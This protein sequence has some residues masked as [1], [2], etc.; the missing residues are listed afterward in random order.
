MIS[1]YLV[2]FNINTGS[3][4]KQRKFSG[5]DLERRAETLKNVRNQ[6]ALPVLKINGPMNQGMQEILRSWERLLSNSQQGTG[7][8]VLSP[9]ELGFGINLKGRRICFSRAFGRD[10][11]VANVFKLAM[12]YMKQRNHLHSPEWIGEQRDNWVVWSCSTCGNTETRESGY[13]GSTI[14][15]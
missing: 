12:E 10:A 15:H 9:Q 1:D 13:R 6:L 4:E 7:T 8:A 14:S 11:T 5:W 2:G 3:F